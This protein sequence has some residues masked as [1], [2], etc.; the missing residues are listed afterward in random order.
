MLFCSVRY[1]LPKIYRKNY[2]CVSCAVHSRV[3]RGRSKEDRR[4][5]APPPR[6]RRPVDK[7]D[8]EKKGPG[9]E[10]AAKP[11]GMGAAAAPAAAK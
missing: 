7:K 4:N 5:R 10:R 9:G 8:G 1:V 2:Y 6:F 3:V 11:P